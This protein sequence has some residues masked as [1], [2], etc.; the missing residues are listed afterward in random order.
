MY[1]RAFMANK[2]CNER[3]PP[4]ASSIQKERKAPKNV[5]WKTEKRTVENTE[6]KRHSTRRE[7]FSFSRLD[8]PFSRKK[9]SLKKLRFSVLLSRTRRTNKNRFPRKF[10]IRSVRETNLK[11]KS[12]KGEQDVWTQTK[13]IDRWKRRTNRSS[14]RRSTDGA[15]RSAKQKKQFLSF[16]YFS[17]RKKRGKTL[18][19]FSFRFSGWKT[20]QIAIFRPWKKCRTFFSFL[21]HEKKFP[22]TFVEVETDFFSSTREK[23]RFSFFARSN[24]VFLLFFTTFFQGFF[25]FSAG[26]NEHFQL[27]IFAFF[28]SHVEGRV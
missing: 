13:S 26:K 5:R 2:N 17:T 16:V 12:K 24:A 8:A 21:R 19:F 28:F 23:S 10:S 6:I 25:S 9:V 14:T 7:R 27:S 20:F 11:R 4:R 22:W 15:N 18:F 1:T 3:S